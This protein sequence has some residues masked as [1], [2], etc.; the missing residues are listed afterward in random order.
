MTAPEEKE[1]L[2]DLIRQIDAVLTATPAPD[3]SEKSYD[4]KMANIRL[5]RDSP[6]PA[7]QMLWQFINN[8]E[9]SFDT[10][11]GTQLEPI[12][13]M[14]SAKESYEQAL[15]ALSSSNPAPAA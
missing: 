1:V 11:K 6:D 13:Q 10:W 9:V 4:E 15:K 2:H 5:V 3:V 7:A 8:Q 14:L 12:K